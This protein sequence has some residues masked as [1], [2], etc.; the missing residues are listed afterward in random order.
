MVELFHGPKLKIERAKAHISDLHARFLTFASSNYFHLG[1]EK[2][3]STGNNLV[4]FTITENLPED[5][6]LIIGDAIHNLKSALDFAVSDVLLKQIGARPRHAKSSVYASASRD[7]FIKCIH[8]GNISKAPGEILDFI[9][10]KIR[11]F[12]G[13]DQT[14]CAL[15]ELDIMDKH[16]L[17]LP[18][19][20]VGVLIGASFEDDKGNALSNCDLFVESGRVLLPIST[21]GNLRISDYGR[22]SMSVLF[23][24]GLPLEGQL[25]LPTLTKLAKDISYIVEEFE[26]MSKI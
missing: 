18:I 5:I 7:D 15:H 11:P 12:A 17:L 24:R 8:G 22:P 9:V 20:Q 19:V 25:V 4:K 23:E 13:G 3:P 1:I 16:M 6:G 10:N 14:I 2:N 21:S 26:R